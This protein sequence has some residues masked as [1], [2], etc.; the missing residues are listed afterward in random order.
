M[1]SDTRNVKLGVAKITYNGVDLGYTKGGVEVEVTT[2]THK[3]MVD[4]FGNSE[5]NE[6]IMARTC[7]VRVP[8][9]ETTVENLVRIMP[10]ATLTESSGTQATGT[11][12][13][14]DNPSADETLTINGVRYTFKAEPTG[15][16]QIDIGANLAGT[17]D[18]IVAKLNSATAPSVTRATYTEDGDDT[19]TITYDAK[20]VLGNAFT[21]ATTAG[22]TVSGATLSGGVDSK[23]RVDVSNAI[24]TDLLAQAEELILHPSANAANDVSE[25]FVIPLAATAGALTFAYKLDE[26]RIYNVEFTAYPNPDTNQLFYIGDATA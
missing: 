13:F 19:L 18:N 1:A 26:E 22:A 20:D 6:F 10:G 17:L 5:I 25:D 4:Q 3:V 11:I 8:L 24:S 21:I 14:T 15:D 9:A 16:F 23:K 2:E 12:V 7:K